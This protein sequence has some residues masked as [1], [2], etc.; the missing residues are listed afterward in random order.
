[1]RPCWNNDRVRC[2][3]LHRGDQLFNTDAR[4]RLTVLSDGVDAKRQAI[5]QIMVIEGHDA[6]RRDV[7]VIVL[8][9]VRQYALQQ[10]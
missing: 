3:V 10:G 5:E 4:Q 7:K 1:M 6:L 2:F 8:A 9:D